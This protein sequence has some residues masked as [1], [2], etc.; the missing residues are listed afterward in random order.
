M[1]LHIRTH[2]QGD[3]MILDCDGQLIYGE[4]AASLRQ[5]VKALLVEH[6]KL[7]LNLAEVTYIDSNGIGTLVGLLGLANTAGGKLKMAAPG[8]KVKDVLQVS[9]LTALFG[10]CATVEEAVATFG[11]PDAEST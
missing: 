7:V 6:R 2:T 1:K 5:L 10:A 9:K 8:A 11:G 3:I 4:E